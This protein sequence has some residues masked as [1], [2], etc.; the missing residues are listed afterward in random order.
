MKSTGT[1]C[2]TGIRK[3]SWAHGYKKRKT[4]KRP[5]SWPHPIS[6]L[7]LK[8]PWNSSE[9]GCRIFGPDSGREY[10]ACPGK[11]KNLI[12]NKNVKFSYYAS[13]W[14]KAYIL[15]FIMDNW[16]MVKIGTTQGQRKLFFR[17][18]KENKSSLKRDLIPGPNYCQNAWGSRNRKWLRWIN[19]WTA[20]ISPLTSP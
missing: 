6:G 8:L 3:L 10:R 2:W 7:W 16:R 5:I 9:S 1:S 15:K 13:F 14:I 17:L 20:G 4:R 18:K 19:G 12:P 11:L